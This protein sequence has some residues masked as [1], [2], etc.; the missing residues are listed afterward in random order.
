MKSANDQNGSI[1]HYSFKHNK[2]KNG[3]NYYRLKM[4]DKEGKI[5]YSQIKSI[6]IPHSMPDIHTFPNPVSSLYYLKLKTN[7]Q[8]DLTLFDAY[9]NLISKKYVKHTKQEPFYWDL[10]FLIPGKYILLIVDEYGNVFVKRI[11]KT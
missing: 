3:N 2:P 6:Y 8:Y 9:G 7:K 5:E 4:I 11:V 1:K 10:S